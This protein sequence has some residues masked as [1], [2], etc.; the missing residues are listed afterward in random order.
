MG[1]RVKPHRPEFLAAL[2]A[3]A[4][5]CSKWLRELAEAEQNM[6]RPEPRRDRVPPSYLE[7]ELL[8]RVKQQCEAHYKATER[9]LVREFTENEQ[10]KTVG[11]QVEPNRPLFISCPCSRCSPFTL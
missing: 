2:S 9:C 4:V 11:S 3:A 1:Y 7:P 8:E 10:F 5:E 6:K